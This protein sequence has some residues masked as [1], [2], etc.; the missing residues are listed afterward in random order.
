[1]KIL[2][3]I[4]SFLI[5][6]SIFANE[7]LNPTEK[8]EFFGNSKNLVKEET[9]KPLNQALVKEGECLKYK[10]NGENYWTKYETEIIKIESVGEKTL[11]T[12]RISFINKKSD[13]WMDSEPYSLPFEFQ[14]NYEVIDCPKIEDKMSDEEVKKIKKLLKK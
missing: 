11:K 6:N 5:F 14:M 12:R 13:K 2:I 4:F 7:L 1:M 3:M 9:V 10:K 8:E